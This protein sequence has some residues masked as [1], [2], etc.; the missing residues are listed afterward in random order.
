MRR[1]PEK[2]AV[3]YAKALERMAAYCARAE[4][5]ISDVRKKL[6]DYGLSQEEQEELIE[7]L[8]RERFIDESRY[9]SAFVK[10][11]SQLSRWGVKKIEQAL[12]L[13][14]IPRP[15][16]QQALEAI[17]SDHQN[18]VLETLL[19]RKRTSI[20]VSSPYDLQVKLTRFALSRGFDYGQI[21]KTLQKLLTDYVGMD[22]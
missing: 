1:A 17:D 18:E 8:I 11:K 2:R 15:I 22:D 10:E 4:H 9:A 14:G 5:C 13:K 16:I 7:R 20:K 21:R 3:P 6:I 12:S 19:S